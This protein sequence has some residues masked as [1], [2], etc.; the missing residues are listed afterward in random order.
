MNSKQKCASLVEVDEA[1][2]RQMEASRAAL[3]GMRFHLEDMPCRNNGGAL[4]RW[5]IRAAELIR[6]GMVE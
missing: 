4:V 2:L 1:Y 3:I 5:K 6:Q